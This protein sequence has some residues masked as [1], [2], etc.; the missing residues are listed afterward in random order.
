MSPT[1]TPSAATDRGPD[2][3]A[4][5]ADRD[6]RLALPAAAAWLGAL[7][8]GG[9][10][11]VWAVLALLGVLGCTVLPAVTSRFRPAAPTLAA[12]ALIGT[13]A[14]GVAWVRAEAVAHDPVTQ[15]AARGATVELRGVVTSD[16]VLREG[17]FDDLTVLRLRVREVTGRGTT[18]AVRVPVV[19]LAPASWRDRLR[20]GADVRLEGRLAASDERTVA[21][22]VLA[23]GDPV[24][25]GRPD[26]WWRV[27]ER[28]R[29]SLRESVA[30][31]PEAQ[32]ALVPA[33]VVGDDAGLPAQ[34]Q[35][36]FRTTGLTHL[37]AVSGT[38]LTLLVG[39]LLV[40]SRW[41]GVR[42][43][44][45]LVVAV[46]G[47][48]TF[49]VLARSEPSVVRAATMGSVGL[50]AL[51]TDGRRAGARALS[52][53][54]IVLL[55]WDPAMARSAGFAL[56][57]LATG[58]IL[59]FAPAYRDA[60]ARWM[61]R[62]A[63]EAIAVPT[64]AQ[65]ACTPIVAAL[66]GQVSLVAVAANLVVA[67]VVGPATVLGLLGGFL[68]LLWRPLGA[69]AGTLASWFVAWLV[70]V[71]EHGAALPTAQ[72]SW[73]TGVVGLSA[74]TVLCVVLAWLLPGVL[75]R[76]AS[77]AAAALVLTVTVLVRLPTPGWPPP[78]WLL[79]ACDV[80]QGDALVVRVGENAGVLVDAGPDPS[81]VDRCL[82]ALAIDALP[83]VVLSHFHA[84]HVDG[85]AGAVEGR[86]VGRLLTSSLADPPGEAAEVAGWARG[87]HVP[88]T[89]AGSGQTGSVGGA[90]WQVLWPPADGSQV[91]SEGSAANNASVVLLLVVDGVRILLTGDVEPEAQ[92]RIAAAYPGL[93]ADVLKLP[94]HG[95]RHQ[96]LP[97]LTGLGADL[98]LVS[99]GADNDYGHPAAASLAPFAAYGAAV[100]RTD[101]AGDVVVSTEDGVLGVRTRRP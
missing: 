7:A 16:P 44:W 9:G 76:R 47:I 43:R 6:L 40:V 80:G 59:L 89:V 60:L 2:E 66:S 5:G 3:E 10:S 14:L 78:G 68:G 97:F 33:L 52:V 46:A 21:G 36:D 20:L 94:H 72:I 56:S 57:A 22:L 51:A 98:V 48:A 64:A 77:S 12:T 32:R 35:E 23:R 85:L 25:V 69:L 42:G 86:P 26:V 100:L 101:L 74:L 55:L 92:R 61:P 58:G 70:W 50:V 90:S 73:A 65:L 53:A 81:A 54:V 8:G 27:A 1:L 93:Q 96:D 63:A 79:A 4:E 30:H 15:L 11:V 99:V 34:L 19:V 95:S 24:V 29:A 39:F 17:R 71:A 28:V 91:P 37:T 18:Y 88:V 87:A 67:P 82:D 41:L 75:R 13:S 49:L 38:N 83:L 62:W 31:R 45:L 84:D